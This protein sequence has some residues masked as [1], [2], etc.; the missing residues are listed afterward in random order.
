MSASAID[1]AEGRRF[2]L[3]TGMG[4]RPA[5]G[6]VRAAPRRSL[7]RLHQCAIQSGGRGHQARA[8]T[9]R[10]AHSIWIGAL[11]RLSKTVI[12]S[13][14]MIGPHPSPGPE[15]GFRQWPGLRPRALPVDSREDPGGRARPVLQRRR[16]AGRPGSRE[17]PQVRHEIDRDRSPQ[18]RG[19]T[20]WRSGIRRRPRGAVLA[21]S[22]CGPSAA[23]GRCL[24]RDAGPPPRR[25]IT[26]CGSGPRCR[27]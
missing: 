17:L 2:E 26:A 6:M 22:H 8:A 18:R 19:P 10:R 20:A 3:G 24:C 23:R 4:A 25:R 16:A 7:G 13:T 9:D 1:L 21:A 5:A 27:A 15:H 12:W 14:A 11:C